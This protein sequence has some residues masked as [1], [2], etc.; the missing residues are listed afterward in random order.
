MGKAS[1][2][3]DSANA[4][5]LTAPSII[6]GVNQLLDYVLIWLRNA[7]YCNVNHVSLEFASTENQCFNNIL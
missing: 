3:E 1:L 5:Q 6:T 7:V 4:D 2:S